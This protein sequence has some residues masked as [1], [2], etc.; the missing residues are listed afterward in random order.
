[1]VYPL[2]TPLYAAIPRGISFNP[3]SLWG[4]D[5]FL[6]LIKTIFDPGEKISTKK[7]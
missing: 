5:F 7:N 3:Y 1:L 4:F 6:A 2:P